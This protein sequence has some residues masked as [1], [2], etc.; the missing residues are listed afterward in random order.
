MI[1]VV[2]VDLN[3]LSAARGHLKTINIKKKREKNTLS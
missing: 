1:F 3:D 2:P